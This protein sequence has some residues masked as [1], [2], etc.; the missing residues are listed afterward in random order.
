MKSKIEKL[1]EKVA[2]VNGAMN[3]IEYWEKELEK[4]DRLYT[5]KVFELNVYDQVQESEFIGAIKLPITTCYKLLDSYK[6][7]ATERLKS[8]KITL[9]ELLLK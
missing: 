4:I 3:E 8:S 1:K 6:K 7:V 5:G 9:D 2:I